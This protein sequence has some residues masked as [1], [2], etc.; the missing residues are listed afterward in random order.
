MMYA[1][2]ASERRTL[3]MQVTRTNIGFAEGFRRQP[4]SKPSLQLKEPNSELESCC[5]L[6]F[7][8]FASCISYSRSRD[9]EQHLSSTIQF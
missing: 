7:G 4:H 1:A 3:Q 6:N 5:F 9:C 2:S 8:I